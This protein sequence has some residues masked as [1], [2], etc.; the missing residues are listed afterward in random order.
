[1]ASSLDLFDKVRKSGIKISAIV[2]L[3]AIVS[4]VIGT[5]MVAFQGMGH[6]I[7][8]QLEIT[9]RLTHAMDTVR[10]A[11]VHFKKQVQEWKNILIRGR[12]AATF[13]KYKSQ[14][15][16]EETIVR[17]ELT[18]LRKT[19]QD[20]EVEQVIDRLLSE[21]NTLGK[22]Y[23]AALKDYD[24]SLPESYRVVDERVKGIDRAP[25]KAMDELVG[26]LKT[27]V[28]RHFSQMEDKVSAKVE[29]VKPRRRMFLYGTTAILALLLGLALWLYLRVFR[30]LSEM[31]AYF[32]E[33]GKANLNI[34]T[35]IR[36]H[37]EIGQL[38][39][40]LK[41]MQRNLQ[42]VIADT[43]RVMGAVA[44][45]DLTEKINAH[46]PGAFAELKD[47][48][49]ATIEK[50]TSIVVD[51][52]QAAESVN[53][54]AQEIARGTT[55]LAQRTEAQASSLEQTAASMEQMT[56]SVKQNADHA[57]HA[58]IQA[59]GAGEQAEKGGQAMN[60]MIA[61][62]GEINVSSKKI[63]DIIVVIDEIAAQTNLLALN[64]AIEAAR[65]GEAGH[66]F[67]VV[68]EE[69]RDLAQRS[70]TAANEIKQLIQD[71]V[72]KVEEGMRLVDESGQGLN[73]IV[74][75]VKQ[76][77]QI[78]AEIAAASRDQSIG[79]G[80]VNTA[81][82]QMDAMTQQNA[83]MV[84]QTATASQT[85]GNMAIQLTELVQYF[86][87]GAPQGPRISNTINRS[88]NQSRSVET[89]DTGI[90]DQSSQLAADSIDRGEHDWK[91]F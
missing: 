36:R 64:A 7:G 80:Q 60:Q 48:V 14:F 58:S 71:S 83:A 68:A 44:K 35:K 74:A 34:S 8:E 12:D 61:A 47:N 57:K 30:P 91:E 2:L 85:M 37:D 59:A 38:L 67:A 39:N 90:Q 45:G 49:N 55:D 75:A 72:G 28:Q 43:V 15:T 63:A 70:A 27:Q 46:Y 40:E 51:T 13:D 29:A 6:I 89:V 86:R 25:T 84:E 19:A 11:Q 56:A 50:L 87:V 31:S 76:V 32:R 54:G 81:I 73:E 1:M 62:M 69:V 16:H 66:G 77:N 88:A 21:H 3:L 17:D 22:K 78:V 33:I 26:K 18:S 42:R 9:V 41:T 24:G 23:R 65:A 4:L 79:I 82:S 52:K 20:P 53:T 10:S 5:S